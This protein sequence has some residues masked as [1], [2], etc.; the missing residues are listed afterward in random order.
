MQ[1]A[2][3]FITTLVLAL[4]YGVRI[5]A[6][7]GYVPHRLWRWYMALPI[8]G[9]VIGGALLV[10]RVDPVMP[11]SIAT[12]LRAVV[13]CICSWLGLR[14]WVKHRWWDVG[15]SV[16][17]L[18]LVISYLH[19]RVILNNVMLAIIVLGMS[20]AGYYASKAW[21]RVLFILLAIFDAYAVWFSGLMQVISNK[22]SGI[23]PPQFF[24]MMQLP[25]L[26]IGTMDVIM[27]AIAVVA[28][29]RHRGVWR[30]VGF[31]VWCIASAMIN[32]QLAMTGVGWLQSMPYMVCLAPAV[33]LCLMGRT[34]SR[35]AC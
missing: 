9:A 20:V 16:L 29:E 25:F 2:A 19:W 4:L 26:E 31:V 32:E 5:R 22:G 10:V 14:F 35:P 13:L 28:I 8:V 17:A 34:H 3:W 30:A 12:I 7:V 1:T 11:E 21:I 27:A 33:L 18:M 24:T 15:A 23:F 6:V